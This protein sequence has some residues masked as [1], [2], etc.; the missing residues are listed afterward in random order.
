MATPTDNH[1]QRKLTNR[2]LQ[3]IALGGAIGTGLFY[4][5]ASTISLTGPAIILS[6]FLGGIIVFLIMRMLGEMCV[7][8]PISGSFSS[9]AEKFWGEFPAYLSGWSYLTAWILC[10]MAELTAI[11]IY[12]NFWFPDVPQWTT[13]LVCLLLVTAANLINVR[14]YG[15]LETFMSMVKVIAVICMI[16]F[17]LYLLFTTPSYGSFPDNFSNIW[18]I[19]GFFPHGWYG[20]AC[21]MAVVLFSFAGIELIGMTAAEVQDPEKHMPTAINQVLVRIM[22]FYVGTM[23]VLMALFPWNQIGTSGSP[24]VEIFS[25]MGITIAAHI[26]NFVVMIAALSV[27]N[28]GMYANG[29]MLYS[30]AK[31]GKAPKF[32]A[33]VSKNGVPVV[34]TLF[35]SGITLI[36]VV[37]NFF[38]PDKVFGYLM[39]LVVV[40]LIVCWVSIVITHMKFRQMHIKAGT[41]DTIKFKS[42]LFPFANYLCLAFFVFVLAI[43]ATMDS[44]RPAVYLLPVWLIIMGVTYKLSHKPAP[45]APE[46]EGVKAL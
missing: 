16:A 9:Y 42:I 34:G 33:I 2:H 11:G 27:Y 8:H 21:S 13:A 12:I 40:V 17:G 38:M 35:S 26:L 31:K 25:K 39:A 6:Y 10:S 18:K 43:M 23:I 37:L 29:R 44:M 45:A 32:L 20:V 14:M 15:E 41:V 19:D 36:A 5:S 46:E 30:L 22:L 3:M 1:L 28:S 7:Q 4:G 24:F